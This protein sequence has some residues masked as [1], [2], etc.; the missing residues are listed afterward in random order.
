MI[1]SR[2]HDA[3]LEAVLAAPDDDVPRLIYADWLEDRGQPERAEFIRLQ[4]DDQRDPNDERQRRCRQL[5]AAHRQEWTI[6]GIPGVQQFRR[7]FVESVRMDA[8]EFVRHAELI[9]RSAPVVRLRLPL[10]MDCLD[11]IAAVPWL[12]RVVKLDLTGNI[13]LGDRL[14]RFFTAVPLPNLTTL[15]LRNSQLWP[16]HCTV[17]AALT[18]RWPR[19]AHLNL[20]GNPIGDIGISN[21]CSAIGPRK[22]ETLI[23]RCDMLHDEDAIHDD[24]AETIAESLSMAGL[25]E[26]DL[27]GQYISDSGFAAIVRSTHLNRLAT[28]SLS[29]TLIGRNPATAYDPLFEEGRLPN[30]KTLLLDGCNLDLATLHRF[31]HWPR[32]AGMS[33]VRLSGES[34]GADGLAMI[35]QSPHP[36]VLELTSRDHATPIES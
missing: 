22:L 24:G 25:R 12:Q 28:L 18:G 20:S 35:S 8:R 1:E 10:A 34:L 29:D 26:L 33:R 6:P 13:G 19:L 23:A 16:E 30:L 11:E 9:G 5:L 15:V 3:L 32:L 4:I 21:L 36:A 14:E 2:E 7:G 31:A 17:L 27:A